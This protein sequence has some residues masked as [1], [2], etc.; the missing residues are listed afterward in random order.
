MDICCW[1]W[2]TVESARL[3]IVCPE[4]EILVF[5]VYFYRWIDGNPHI[6]QHRPY[7]FSIWNGIKPKRMLVIPPLQYDYLC[8]CVLLTALGSDRHFRHQ[9]PHPAAVLLST[10]S[11]PS[12][13]VAVERRHKKQ[14]CKTKCQTRS[15]K[16]IKHFSRQSNHSNMKLWYSQQT[17]R[18]L[19]RRL[20]FKLTCLPTRIV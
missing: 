2:I 1:I 13:G 5:T 4:I 19:H 11:I 12:V 18:L 9:R 6:P 8:R 16:T 15:H 10:T 20:W 7:W 3:R 17:D 14:K